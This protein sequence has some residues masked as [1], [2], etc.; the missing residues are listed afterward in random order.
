MRRSMTR[1]RTTTR[2]KPSKPHARLV[3]LAIPLSAVLLAVLLNSFVIISAIVPSE[4]MADTIEKGSL[5]VA[6]RL[7]Y[8]NN[9]VCRGDIILFVHPDIDEPYIVK[10]VIALPGD[11]L[12]IRDGYVYLNGSDSPLEEQYVSSR[13]SDSMECVTV[14]EN[15]YFVLGDNRCRSVDSRSNDFGFVE[16]ENIRARAVVTLFPKI[17]AL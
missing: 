3:W 11:T 4:S 16:R 14:P 6:S 1:M 13:S 2:S 7:A 8:K 17:K 12:E 15:C 10:R 9:D 5:I